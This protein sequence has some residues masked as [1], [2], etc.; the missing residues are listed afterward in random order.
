MLATTELVV[1]DAVVWLEELDADVFEA[2][3]VELELG[4]ELELDVSPSREDKLRPAVVLVL[5]DDV[6]EADEVLVVEADVVADV[7][8][9]ELVVVCEA[10]LEVVLVAAVVVSVS[11]LSARRNTWLCAR[12][13]F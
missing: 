6:L 13:T 7:F 3:V 8:A 10:E 1:D 9:D 12:A 11:A 2:D 5:V 4:L